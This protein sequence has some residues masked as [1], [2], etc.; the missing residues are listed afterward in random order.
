MQSIRKKTA[1]EEKYRKR[2][3]MAGVKN[4]VKKANGLPVSGNFHGDVRLALDDLCLYVW[5]SEQGEDGEWKLL[6]SPS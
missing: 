4:P 3:V 2:N 6:A 1:K 5:D